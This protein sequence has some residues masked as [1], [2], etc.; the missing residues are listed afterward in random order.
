MTTARK[1]G[2]V[3]NILPGENFIREVCQFAYA[4]QGRKIHEIFAPPFAPKAVQ[5]EH[6]E[7]LALAPGCSMY[8]VARTLEAL[9]VCLPIES[10]REVLVVDRSYFKTLF[11]S[12]DAREGI[13]A[14]LERRKPQFSE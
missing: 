13:N 8:A 11:F 7:R 2:I 5:M 14:F 10:F 1:L 9:E 4:V 12:R 3:D 6:K